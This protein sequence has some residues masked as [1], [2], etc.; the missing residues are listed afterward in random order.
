MTKTTMKAFGWLTTAAMSIAFAGIAQAGPLKVGAAR[1]DITSMGYPDGNMPERKYGHEWLYVRAIVLDNGESKAVLIGADLGGIRPDSVYQESSAAIARELNIPVA[2]IVMSGTHTHSDPRENRDEAQMYAAIVEAARAASANMQAARVGFGE[3]KVYLNVNRDLYSEETGDWTQAPN[4]DGPS[5]K[6]LAVLA[7]YDMQGRP[8][9]GYMNYAM[10]PV[11]GY[12]SGF[13][14]GDFAGAA[15][16]H[17]EDAFGNG[18]VMAFTQGASGDQNPLYLRSSTNVMAA[19]IGVPITGF[20]MTR[21]AIET[22]LREGLVPRGEN[23]ATM[24]EA[25]KRSMDA[26]GQILGEEAIRVMTQMDH[27]AGD[28]TIAGQ[29]TTLTCPGRDRTNSDAGRAGTQAVYQDGPDVNL[30]LGVLAINEIA[31]ASVNAEIYNLIAQQLKAA[32]PLSNTMLVTVANGRA[33]S[34]YVPTDDAYARRTFQVLGSRLK[35]GC[36]QSGIVNTVTD[37]IYDYVD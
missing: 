18:M 35:P 5:D 15:S 34:G 36:A 28:V 14:S 26:Q 37:M 12:L 9:A 32:S 33:N 2:N 27:L 22:P 29:A 23:D 17:I 30:R 24:H 6:T 16:R 13:I 21:E 3:G 11:N 19:A 10:H 25:L 20:D 31:I 8:I 7:F 4:P 1:I